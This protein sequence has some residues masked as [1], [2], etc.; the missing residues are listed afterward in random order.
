MATKICVIIKESLFTIGTFLYLILQFC[1]EK[2]AF[3]VK[4]FVVVALLKKHER[5]K[6]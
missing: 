4:A 1:V 3:L 2:R 5:K 6:M